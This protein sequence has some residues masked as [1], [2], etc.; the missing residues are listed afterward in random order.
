MSKI[1]AIA[2]RVVR[3][4]NATLATSYGAGKTVRDH[5]F[6][7]LETDD[8]VVGFAEGSPLP[9]FSGEQAATMKLVLDETLAPSVIGQ[10]V[11][12]LEALH[13]RLERAIAGHHATK[14][15]IVN[16][17]YDALGKTLSRPVCDLLGGRLRSKVDVAGAIGIVPLKDVLDRAREFYALGVR[18][19]KLKVGTDLERDSNAVRLIREEFGSGV[20]IRADANGGF[21]RA[22]A[23]RFLEKTE[24]F[25]LQ[26][27][28]QPLNPRDLSGLAELRRVST[29]PIA[30][31]E[32]L[33]S[34]SDA[35]A[36]IRAGAADVFVIKLIKLGGLHNA[37]KV[38]SIAEAAGV[39]CVVVSPYETD[40]GSSA[41]LHLAS[42]SQAFSYACE[43]GAGVTAVKLEGISRLQLVQGT[44]ALPDQPGLGVTVTPEFFTNGAEPGRTA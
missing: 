35:I 13:V 11:F 30:I 44:I 29:T 27:V 41:N 17:V 28:E 12:D 2:S 40:L 20:E 37:R 34:P 36:A 7:R 23:R 25:D 3:V 42:S 9:H 38:A 10:T 4:Q 16:A 24:E 5:L 21:T 31:D 39:T 18:T 15:A 1:A 6:V 32:G 8:G 19:F 43:V 26:Y 22:E 33:F 14:S